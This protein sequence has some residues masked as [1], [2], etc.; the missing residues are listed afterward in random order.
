[1]K[2]SAALTSRFRGIG[3]GAAL[4][5][6]CAA[7]GFAA[8]APTGTDI[9]SRFG[10][11]SLLATQTR[12]TGFG[13]NLSELNQLFAKS[14]GTAL[15]IGITGNIESNGNGA[16]ILLDTKS[17][18]SSAF[19]YTGGDGSGR[20]NEL[21]G[22]TLDTG[23]EP[24]YAVDVNNS[25]GILYVDLYDLQA[26]TKAYLGNCVDL[27]GASALTGGGAVAF[28]NSNTVGVSD[29]SAAD[30]NGYPLAASATTG[31]EISLPLSQ[32]GATGTEA[33]I[34]AVV[35]GGGGYVSNQV[36]P[37][38]PD[39]YGN[40]AGGPTDYQGIPGEQNARVGLTTTAGDLDADTV[41]WAYTPVFLTGSGDV[42]AH[43]PVT[44]T[45]T[46]LDDVAYV[47]E[48]V[49]NNLGAHTANIV[50]IDA[51]DTGTAHLVTT[52]GAN[53]RVT[54]L[55]SPVVGRV[56]AYYANGVPRLYAMTTNGTLYV[57][58]AGTG[59]NVR[60]L[61]VF[62]GGSSVSTPAVSSVGGTVNIIV[63]GKTALGNVQL[64]RVPDLPVLAADGTLN[65]A[66]ATDVISSPS[67]IADGSRVQIATINGPAGAVYTV[68]TAT[69]TVFTMANL[70]GPAMASPT[71]TTDPPGYML[72]GTTVGPGGALYAFNASNA[73][74]FWT[75]MA[76]AGIRD[77]VYVD[78]RAAPNHTF[79]GTTGTQVL[80]F[81]PGAGSLI[82]FPGITYPPATGT[83]VLLKP[84]LTGP[85]GTLY[86]PTSGGMYTVNPD[87]PGAAGANRFPVTARLTSPSVT[88][89]ASG[90]VM[91]ATSDN[92]AGPTGT[93]GPAGFTG[94]NVYGLAVQ[95]PVPVSARP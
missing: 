65:L 76:S 6:C 23:F 50:A 52:F 34:M 5:A 11:G 55:D 8:W 47:A 68:D 17:G 62:P 30:A 1:M 63:A 66:Q 88:G 12:P 13:N 70:S 61:Q 81:A 43:P 94:G 87:S 38:L 84:S 75:A 45:P 69:F 3:L 95:A 86:L 58:D 35:I 29:T 32:I 51:K 91:A 20:I 39:A 25:G 78:Y 9:P 2:R 79:V 59:A 28:N 41:P 85:G 37:G 92:G 82:G 93:A 60:S 36:L 42:D 4:A 21:N 53:G 74:L 83:P 72:V 73:N 56:A 26:N 64:V 33:S 46:I 67:A 40:L 89:A 15:N 16:V 27:G 19:N 18:G 54:G 90:D 57:M 44:S 22:D 31:L 48:D 10:M 71:L 80:G 14:D 49:V 24:D 7:P 77:A